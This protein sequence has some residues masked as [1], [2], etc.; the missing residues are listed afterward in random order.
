MLGYLCHD[1]VTTSLKLELG[2]DLIMHLV[3]ISLPIH[4][5]Q[6]QSAKRANDVLKLIHTDICGHFPRTSW[7]G[8][9]YFITFIDDYSRYDYLYLIHEKSQPLDV[10]KSFKV[11]VEL[12]LGKKMKAIKSDCGS[13]YHDRY[14][15]SIE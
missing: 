10:F 2:K 8:Q 9:Q 1:L 4:F 3:F 15:G 7:N 13:E 6:F 5:G 14:D 11:E 12:Q